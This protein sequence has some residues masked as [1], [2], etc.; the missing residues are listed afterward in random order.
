MQACSLPVCARGLQRICCETYYYCVRLV[1]VVCLVQRATHVIIMEPVAG[2]KAYATATEAQAV[3]RAHR[4]GGGERA[5][6]LKVRV[7]V[8]QNPRTS[9]AFGQNLMFVTACLLA[10]AVRTQVVRFVYRDCADEELFLRNC[11]E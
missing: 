4:Q 11:L 8:R 10:V 3:G 5:I 9:Q 7:P 6:P 1:V 2:S